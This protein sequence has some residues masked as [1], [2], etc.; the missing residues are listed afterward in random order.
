M[1][2][3]VWIEEQSKDSRLKVCRNGHCYEN[4][5]RCCR[6]CGDQKVAERIEKDAV[7][8][9]K[10]LY[11]GIHGNKW[12]LTTNPDIDGIDD[13]LRSVTVDFN[14]KYRFYYYL[15]GRNPH[16][17]YFN[18]IKLGD[19]TVVK[20]EDIVKYCDKI[21]KGQSEEYVIAYVKKQ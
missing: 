10:K 13:S 17:F 14:E 4:T 3:Q 16:P 8:S 6:W 7:F 12:V 19:G 5:G 1:K 21:I 9:S 20:G 11:V 15:D 2:E 18:E